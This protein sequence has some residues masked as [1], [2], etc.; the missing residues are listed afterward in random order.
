MQ[1]MQPDLSTLQ[2]DFRATVL[3]DT[4]ADGAEPKPPEALLAAVNANGIPPERRL[5]IHRNHFAT[6]LVDSLGGVFEATRALLGPEFFDAF[7]K[8]YVR[9]HPPS[10]PG[11][12]EY[13]GAFPDALA[14]TPGLADHGYVIDVARLEWAMHES[15]HAPAAPALQPTRLTALPAD[16]IGDAILKA[17]PT[18]RLIQATF[19]VHALWRGAL[20]NAV[21]GA[22]L[23]GEPAHLILSRPNL[24]VELEPLAPAAYSFVS[25]LFA[26]QSI[27]T[28]AGTAASAG[29]TTGEFD[30]GKTLGPALR[31]LSLPT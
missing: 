29:A 7:A 30:L 15:F 2:A 3:A 18:V 4:N 14:N 17:H 11:L 25:E 9:A 20:D 24:D 26:G 21:D 16:Q 12:F 27:D 5:A 23:Q 10:A 6:T 31:R 1:L 8:R 19:P 22:M 28:A 13:G